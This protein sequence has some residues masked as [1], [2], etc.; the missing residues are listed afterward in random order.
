MLAV[1]PMGVS[2]TEE[3]RETNKPTTTEETPEKSKFTI[4]T[5]SVLTRL[6]FAK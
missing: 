5:P 6:Y 1:L 4:T 2:A 3:T